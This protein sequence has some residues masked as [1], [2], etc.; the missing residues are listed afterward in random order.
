[1]KRKCQLEGKLLINLNGCVQQV[2]E[3]QTVVT[4][5]HQQG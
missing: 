1:M 3:D 5:F 4:T 2:I